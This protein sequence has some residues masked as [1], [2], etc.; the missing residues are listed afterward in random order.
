M[1]DINTFINGFKEVYII[2]FWLLVFS[3]YLGQDQ[4]KAKI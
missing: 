3:P 1:V 2:T 4:K